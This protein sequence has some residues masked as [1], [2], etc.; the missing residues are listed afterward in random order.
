ME[1]GNA[2]THGEWSVAHP[3]DGGRSPLRASC[4]FTG[5]AKGWIDNAT[6]ADATLTFQRYDLEDLTQNLQQLGHDQSISGPFVEFLI[7]GLPHGNTTGFM[8][9]HVRVLGTFRSNSEGA[10][11]DTAFASQF[12]AVTLANAKDAFVDLLDTTNGDLSSRNAG[13]VF[14]QR[15]APSR[16][17]CRVTPPRTPG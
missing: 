12:D 13:T 8:D 15:A 3:W 14:A 6:G 10:V 7:A 16:W 1:P 9:A 4:T 5:F 2:S 17:R 11:L